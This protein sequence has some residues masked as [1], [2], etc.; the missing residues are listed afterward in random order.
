M[1]NVDV[2]K[3]KQELEDARLEEIKNLEHQ[4]AS[5]G[6]IINESFEENGFLKDSDLGD[7]VRLI[8]VRN[9]K[10]KND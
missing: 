4:I 1:G 3:L 6:N 10:L 8:N 5:L 7:I 9:K 2:E